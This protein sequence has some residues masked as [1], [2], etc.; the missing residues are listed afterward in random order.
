MKEYVNPEVEVVEID[1]VIVTSPIEG[2]TGGGSD[3]GDFALALCSGGSLWAAAGGA[4]SLGP[5]K[6]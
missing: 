2:G 4:G 5:R 1:D 3:G 6:E